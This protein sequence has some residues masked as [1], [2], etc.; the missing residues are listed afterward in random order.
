MKKILYLPC[1]SEKINVINMKKL[2]FAGLLTAIVGG[3]VVAASLPFQAIL[4]GVYSSA[5]SGS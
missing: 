4:K 1:S 5:T 2:F 3:S